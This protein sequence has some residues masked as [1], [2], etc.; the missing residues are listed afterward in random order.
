MY[1][2][3]EVNELKPPHPLLSRRVLFHVVTSSWEQLTR[4]QPASRVEETWSRLMFASLLQPQ[5]GGGPEGD[6]HRP[7][8][9]P[10]GGGASAWR[11]LHP[12][13]QP[14]GGYALHTA[15]VSWRWSCSWDAPELLSRCSWVDADLPL[16][17]QWPRCASASCSR[18]SS[19]PGRLSCTPDTS[20]CWWSAR[21]AAG[22]EPRHAAPHHAT[23]HHATL[24]FC[25]PRLKRRPHESCFLLFPPE[26]WAQ[27]E[28]T[29][30][31]PD[32]NQV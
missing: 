7:G 28:Q 19:P 1:A 30:V 3:Y 6:L 2:G 18:T 8:P 32:F 17:L 4:R 21:C 15:H 9:G 31:Q 25:R 10:G 11:L 27:P 16:S 13:H 12:S 26:M 29:G 23:P 24:S 14:P 22:S 20:T 5:G